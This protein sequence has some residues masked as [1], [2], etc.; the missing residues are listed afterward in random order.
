MVR[1]RNATCF[2]LKGGGGGVLTE[3]VDGA[4]FVENHYLISD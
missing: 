4:G 2:A 3:S 1:V